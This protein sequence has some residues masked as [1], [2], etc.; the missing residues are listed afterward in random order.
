MLVDGAK[1][2]GILL[3]AEASADAARSRVGIGVN[4]VAAPE[5]HAYSG[6]LAADAWRRRS[7]PRHCSWRCPTPGSNPRHLG[8][9]RGFAAIRTAWLARA[10]GLGRA[11][12]LSRPAA[13]TV[14][15]TF[16][17]I[18]E[19][20]CVIVDARPTASA[21]QITAGEVHFGAVAS[22]GAA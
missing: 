22:A 13:A 2:A 17:T 8:Q 12:A 9:R 7:T 3:E 19:T 10:A 14:A 15:G 5:G 11:G 1:L 6:D 16:E 4:V 21:V 20:G 18:D